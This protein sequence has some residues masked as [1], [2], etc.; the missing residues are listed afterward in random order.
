MNNSLY[1]EFS[2]GF[3]WWMVVLAVAL[4]V[5]VVVGLSQVVLSKNL[6]LRWRFNNRLIIFIS[7]IFSIIFTVLLFVESSAG[8]IQVLDNNLAANDS[9]AWSILLMPGAIIVAG[10]I[11][12]ALLY[13]VGET[14]AF[15][16]EGFLR[17]KVRE[18]IK[19]ERAKKAEMIDLC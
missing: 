16:R 9:P 17:H 4:V 18:I 10:G 12:F 2:I 7:S 3:N 13:F 11:C 1:H 6:K 15:Y 5:M 19:N 14:A 8:I